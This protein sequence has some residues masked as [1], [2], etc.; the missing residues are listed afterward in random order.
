MEKLSRRKLRR[1]IKHADAL[2]WKKSVAFNDCRCDKCGTKL[3]DDGDFTQYAI[4]IEDEMT[5]K[6]VRVKCICGEPVAIIFKK[7]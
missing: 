2:V 3:W 7:R 5:D 4:Q 6:I 1:T